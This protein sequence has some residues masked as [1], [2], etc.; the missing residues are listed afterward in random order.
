MLTLW[1]VFVLFFCISNRT[2]GSLGM[3]AQVHFLNHHTEVHSNKRKQK[4]NAA[5]QSCGLPKS[6]GYTAEI[7]AFLIGSGFL[8]IGITQTNF[9]S[10]WYY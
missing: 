2:M 3:A 8:L 1:L 6:R 9:V 4:N 7:L 10:V 5:T